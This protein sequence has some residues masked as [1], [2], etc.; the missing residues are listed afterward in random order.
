VA[1]AGKLDPASFSAQVDN[2]WFP[3]K[4]G[5]VY[6]YR[7][8][9][10]GKPAFEVLRVTDRVKR[11]LGVPNVV[12]DDRLYLDGKL[13]EVTTDWYTQDRRGA[14]WYFGE[15][16]ATLSPTGKLQSREG[17]FQAGV[18]GARPGM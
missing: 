4:P 2:P 3:L 8:S 7:G 10:D 1:A 12:I 18:D 11:I 15:K 17:S 9:K 6:R 13:A 5:T 16:T 14:V